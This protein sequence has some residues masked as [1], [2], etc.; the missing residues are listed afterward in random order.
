[1]LI[2]YRPQGT[3]AERRKPTGST[4]AL[5]SFWTM[6]SCYFRRKKK[7]AMTLCTGYQAGFSS[8]YEVFHVFRGQYM[9]F[10]PPR[11]YW[12]Q[13]CFFV[14]IAV[15]LNRY[16][17]EKTYWPAEWASIRLCYNTGSVRSMSSLRSRIT[18]ASVPVGATGLS[19]G[20]YRM[21]PMPAAAAA[22]MSR[23]RSPT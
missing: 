6:T 14:Q 15:S 10:P 9:V 13:G 5:R 18:S 12:C 21:P 11:Q 2:T 20:T 23:C 17:M 3:S 7:P 8:F 22:S 4:G 16:T 1:M 19:A